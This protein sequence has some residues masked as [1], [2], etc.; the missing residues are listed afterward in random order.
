[1]KKELFSKYTPVCL[2]HELKEKGFN[3]DVVETITGEFDE[4][5]GEIKTQ[6]YVSLQPLVMDFDWNDFV[7]GFECE[8]YELLDDGT[9]IVDDAGQTMGEYASLYN[10]VY[11]INNYWCVKL[12]GER[13]VEM[14]SHIPFD[15]YYE[16]L[17]CV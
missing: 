7:V 11:Q 17:G 12:V 14:Y 6:H 1:M 15:F 13:I 2:Y 8:S 3:F 5:T 4:S 9:I 16:V 10:G